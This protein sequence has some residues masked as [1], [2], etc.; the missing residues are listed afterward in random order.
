MRTEQPSTGPSRRRG[1]GKSLHMHR[2]CTSKSLQSDF[3]SVTPPQDHSDHVQRTRNALANHFK[4]ISTSL[5]RPGSSRPGR[6]N[7]PASLL[8]LELPSAVTAYAPRFT[9]VLADAE[10]KER[11][12]TGVLAEKSIQQRDDLL[13]SGLQTRSLAPDRPL[14]PLSQGGMKTLM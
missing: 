13:V 11:S 8:W 6:C 5:E 14:W 1:T 12:G 4:V 3:S 7:R 9:P 10:S 2:Q